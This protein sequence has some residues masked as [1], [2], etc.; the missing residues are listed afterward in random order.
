M[1][2]KNLISSFGTMRDGDMTALEFQK[3]I[4]LD[5]FRL[6]HEQYL[7]LCRNGLAQEVCRIVKACLIESARFSHI[8][9]TAA[10]ESEREDCKVIYSV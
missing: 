10:N 2:L 4:H 9:L 5:L 8:D 6:T 1:T 7:Y 3:Q